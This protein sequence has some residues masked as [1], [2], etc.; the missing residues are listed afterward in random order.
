M[1]TDAAPR[2]ID[3]RL[4]RI[5]Q[6]LAALVER[7]KVKDWYSVEEVAAHMGKASFTV[8][9]W[10]RH[11]RINAQKRPYRRGKSAEWMIS[12]DELQRI[13]NLGLLPIHL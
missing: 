3:D 9:E 11:G 8:R 13:Q 1:S 10:C 2:N 4:N 12:H 5:E 7:Q 6:M